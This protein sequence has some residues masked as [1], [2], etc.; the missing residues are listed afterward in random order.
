MS[1]I[2]VPSGAAAWGRI[3]ANGQNMHP[4]VAASLNERA[5]LPLR[6]KGWDEGYSAEGGRFAVPSPQPLSRKGRGALSGCIAEA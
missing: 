5:L 3:T 4:S 2:A 1:L 6:E